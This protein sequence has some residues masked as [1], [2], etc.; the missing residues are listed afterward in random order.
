[1][2]M[3]LMMMMMMY[4]FFSCSFLPVFYCV[5]VRFPVLAF[6]MFFLFYGLLPEIKTD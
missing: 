2:M 5:S 4:D 6:S 3:M 1:M